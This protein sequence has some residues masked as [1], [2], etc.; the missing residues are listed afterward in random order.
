MRILKW[1]GYVGFL[2]LAIAVAAL[3]ILLTTRAGVGLLINVG[4]RLDSGLDVH[5]YS[6]ALLGTVCA[7][8][9]EYAH[10]AL[11]VRTRDVCFNLNLWESADALELSL[12]SLSARDI[13]LT[14]PESAPPATPGRG[15]VP[16]L[17]FAI[18]LE[19]VAVTKFRYQNFKL[20]DISG[21]ASLSSKRLQLEADL[22]YADYQLHLRTSG[23]WQSQTVNA[24]LAV[25]QPLLLQGTVDLTHSDLPYRA[26]LE[27]DALDLEPWTSSPV[28]LSAAE[29]RL[30]GNLFNYQFEIDTGAAMPVLG[31]AQ[32]ASRGSGDRAG[33]TLTA[34]ATLAPATELV[35]QVERLS[36]QGQVGWQPELTFAL[37]AATTAVT[38]RF[39][40]RVLT[41]GGELEL[42]GTPDDIQIRADSL[43][44]NVD[45]FS[46]A[47]HGSLRWHNRSA[48]INSIT[49]QIGDG[50][51]NMTGRVTGNQAS[52]LRAIAEQ[53]PLALIDK[54][55][56]GDVSGTLSLADYPQ[57]PKLSTELQARSAGFADQQ[58]QAITLKYDGS[59][60]RG[61]AV[62]ELEHALGRANA[63]ISLLREQND[64]SARF[65]ELTATLKDPL[66][67]VSMVNGS[68]DAETPVTETVQLKLA[69]PATLRVAAGTLNIDRACFQ[70][71]LSGMPEQSSQTCIDLAYPQGPASLQVQ[72]LQLPAIKLPVGELAAE[73][74]VDA[75]VRIAAFRPVSASADVK[76][77]GLV[78]HMDNY[79]RELGELQLQASAEDKNVRVTIRS[80]GQQALVSNGE[81]TALLA[82][83]LPASEIA[84]EISVTIDGIRLVE[85]FLPMELAYELSELSGQLQASAGVGGTVAAPLIDARVDVAD[86]TWRLNVSGS[87]FHKV[88]LAAQLEE[89]GDVKLTAAGGLGEGSFELDG[90]LNRLGSADTTL[91]TAISF[92]NSR[93]I[94]LPDYK[95]DLSGRLR[96]TMT[97]TAL[98]LNGDL[99]MP[100]ARIVVA[101]LPESAI[102]TS[103][104][105]VIVGSAGK[106]K[107]QQ[108]RTTSIRLKLGDAVHLTAFGL[109]TRLQGLL[110]L[111][112][113]P[114]KPPDLR[115]VV[116]LHDGIFKA[117]GQELTVQQG[118]L[119]FIGPIE[120]PVLDLVATRT[121]QRS[122]GDVTVSL[123]LSGS[124]KAIDTE[125][126]S[127]P[128]LPEGDALALLLTGRTFSEMTSGEQ[129]NAYGAAIALGLYGASG[130]RRNLADTFGLE[131][132]IVEQDRDGEWEVG[133]AVRLQ[134]DLYLRYTYSVFSRL[135]GVLLRY[136]LS[137]R[138]SVQAKTGDAH[139]IEIRYGID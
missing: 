61:Q 81:F 95:A 94:E 105:S 129:T 43:Q 15:F 86:A 119:T 114:G 112:E 29:L 136:R 97:P 6:G 72:G 35:D 88:Q 25:P 9:L 46:L 4:Q 10:A 87:Q 39:D 100:Q 2:L 57:A 17:P 128:P 59:L 64:Y 127:D 54:R 92:D 126:R 101:E 122:S 93:I 51:L 132:I 33:L 12:Q 67:D 134:E 133:A 63:E 40:D 70:T 14:V 48:D 102:S 65:I 30:Q 80:P 53:L 104:D 118:K 91:T 109:Q 26:V 82:E 83:D 106:G 66:R 41:L 98:D 135:G 117:Y 19:Q 20:S 113:T 5:G 115:G 11:N 31:T 137:D 27:A 42:T 130:I 124:A 76:L 47:G 139:S 90:S 28:E 131:E 89:R 77:S 49:L 111:T 23:P 18:E 138:V 38:A 55:L 13:T 62:I 73:A 21:A 7:T 120:D 71:Y 125:V 50:S 116:T 32:L 36:L 68:A 99:V 69:E 108:I 58:T 123:I 52:Q 121:I 8:E 110:T 16:P 103:S 79:R 1:T 24:D 107:S 84:G 60:S 45:G 3:A 96:M 75:D 74:V 37:S 78:A 22:R 44:G 56:R 85:E 34:D